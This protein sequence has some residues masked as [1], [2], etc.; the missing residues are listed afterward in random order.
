M[1]KIL[2]ID[3]EEGI[4]H[5][6]SWMVQNHGHE[7][8]CVHTL[9]DGMAEAITHDYDLVF[10]DVM[11]PDGS[12]LDILTKIKETPSEP[13]VIIMTALGSESGAETAI[14]NGAWD[15]IQKPS[16]LEEMKLP[17]LRALQYR[18]EKGSRKKGIF[19]NREGILG[20]SPELMKCLDLAAHASRSDGSVLITGDTGTGKEL[21]ARAI[22][23]NSERKNH[24]FVVV[25]C[26]ALPSTLVESVLFGH[27]KGAFTG[28]DKPQEGLIL[29]A[30]K[31]TLFLDEAGELPLLLQKTFLRV[32]QEH[33][34]RPLGAA[35]EIRSDFRLLAATNRNLDEM[36][37]K[38]MFRNDLLF[39]LRSF[40]I[41]LPPLGGRSRDIKDIALH[42]MV[43]FCERAQIGTKGLSPEFI[44]AL[45]NYGWPGNVREL[46]QTMEQALSVAR[47]EPILHTIHLPV[48]IRIE[49]ACAL[50]SQ[51]NN[52][53][54]ETMLP[55]HE[56]QAQVPLREV[57]D[58]TEYHYLKALMV[59]TAGNISEVCR[60]SGLSRSSLYDRLKKYNIGAHS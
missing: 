22:H 32:L 14:T 3:D 51:K 29:Q 6:L 10:L 47:S 55:P 58:S 1:G 40:V 9:N 43:R 5:V 17:F 30:D 50:V 27:V 46:H 34:F 56:P 18:Q 28:A 37:D 25:D 35:K 12:G 31:G 33:R 24:D 16:S 60:I 7:V 2:I 26:A 11:L 59:S 57:L 15:Y 13:E 42:Y 36:V 19:F 49:L 52:G 4:C 8:K 20:S 21:F 23:E 48:K 38:G 53:T 45:C 39:R 41:G 54:E 44:E